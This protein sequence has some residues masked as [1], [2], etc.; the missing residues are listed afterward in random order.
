MNR[1]I[2]KILKQWQEESG[3]TS[4]IQF[5]T[6]HATGILTIYTSQPGWLIGKAGCYVEKYEKILKKCNTFEVKSIEIQEV[7]GYIV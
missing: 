4:P 5:K 7:D 6:P 3:A 2:C 1:Y